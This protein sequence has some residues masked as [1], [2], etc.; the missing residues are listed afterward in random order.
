MLT[1]R[2]SVP[3]CPLRCLGALAFVAL[4]ACGDH[5]TSAPSVASQP[6]P[7]SAS[8]ELSEA[9]RT[10][11]MEEEA[12]AIR[13]R[14]E[15]VKTM[16]GTVAEKEEAIR[17]LDERQRQLMREGEGNRSEGEPH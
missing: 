4:L 5:R 2:C 7:E 14:W 1:S 17:E 16:E 11:R 6:T 12:K 13:E 10:R 9:E 3:M 15:E 8:P